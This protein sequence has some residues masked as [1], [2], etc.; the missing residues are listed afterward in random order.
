MIHTKGD[1]TMNE[2]L[3]ALYQAYTK[4]QQYK[5]Q[6]GKADGVFQVQGQWM[7]AAEIAAEMKQ[8]LAVAKAGK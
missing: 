7:T 4:V 6:H 2:R 1:T 5:A 8:L 3:A